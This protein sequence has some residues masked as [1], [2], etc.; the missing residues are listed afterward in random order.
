MAKDGYPVADLPVDGDALM[1]ALTAGPTNAAR[2]GREIRETISL[3]Q[4]KAFFERLPIAIQKEIEGHWGRRKM[5]L[6]L[7]RSL[8]LSHCR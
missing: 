7:R 3:N 5:T 1:R 2:D 4:Y 6:I 8:S